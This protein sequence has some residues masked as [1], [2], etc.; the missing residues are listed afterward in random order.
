[1]TRALGGVGPGANRPKRAMAWMPKAFADVERVLA[2][3]WHAEMSKSIA[4][5]TR[6]RRAFFALVRD[7]RTAAGVRVRLRRRGFGRVPRGDRDPGAIRRP[8]VPAR[9]ERARARGR[10]R[11]RGGRL[12]VKTTSQTVGASRKRR[13]R[14]SLPRQGFRRSPSGRPHRASVPR[15]GR[16]SRRRPGGARARTPRSNLPRRAARC[17][18]RDDVDRVRRR[19]RPHARR[20]GREKQTRRRRHR[21]APNVDQG[22]GARRGPARGEGEGGAALDERRRRRGDA[23]PSRAPIMEGS[24]RARRRDADPLPR[25]H[26]ASSRRRRG[27]RA[28]HSLSPRSARVHVG[29]RVGVRLGNRSARRRRSSPR[30]SRRVGLRREFARG[31][32]SVASTLCG[33]VSGVRGVRLGRRRGR[34]T[35]AEHPRGSSRR[36]AA[37]TSISDTLSAQPSPRYPSRS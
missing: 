29:L 16:A 9:S 36:I 24:P 22:A 5:S 18:P 12:R 3:R 23:S 15:D 10:F 28:R 13:A 30:A 20:V 26:R 19:R 31:I 4:S 34:S 27:S 32:L 25:R 11:T 7:V 35:R 37:C 21:Q 8:G 6:E 2:E 17:A 33:V 1:M 14:V